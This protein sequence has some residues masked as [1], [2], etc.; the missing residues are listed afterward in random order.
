MQRTIIIF[1][2]LLITLFL[3]NPGVEGPQDPIKIGQK[4]LETPQGT[5]RYLTTNR[6]TKAILFLHGASSSK[7]IW[8]NQY[9]IAPKGYK[10]IFVDLLGYGESDTPDSG[11]TLAN[12]IE[13]IH[14]IL[15]KEKVDK[16]CIVAHSNG[17]IF[18]KEFYRKYPDQILRLILLDGGLKQMISGPML[19]WMKSTLER[20]DFETFMKSNIEAM[21]TEGLGKN[22][23][24]LLKTDALKV[25]KAVT[26]AE[27]EM[28]SDPATWEDLTIKC[29]VTIV[30]SNN[31]LW[32]E[33][34]AEWLPNV[35]PDHQLIQWK[36]SGHFMPLQHPGRLNQLIIETLRTEQGNQK[37]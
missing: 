34:Y 37:K 20:S 12:W 7:N 24:D 15:E 8:R 10:N 2:P 21:K 28:V 35:V 30:H 13:G 33:A 18:A 36:D 6:G 4:E 14:A 23:A 1:F 5:W 16:V 22:D 3:A 17:V 31:P 27:F 11:Y 19:D 9:S 29:P 26:T 25:S 32:D